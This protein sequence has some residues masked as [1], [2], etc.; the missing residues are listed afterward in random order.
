M[1]YCEPTP[2][3]MDDRLQDL[4]AGHPYAYFF[5]KNSEA[6]DTPTNFKGKKA[7]PCLVRV[8]KSDDSTVSFGSVEYPHALWSPYLTST[9]RPILSFSGLFH[10][11]AKVLSPAVAH[12]YHSFQNG[13]ACR[14]PAA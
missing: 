3:T 11:A 12:A 7:V 5:D 6:A 10:S 14:S 8:T 4:D 9:T 1:A 13:H 2:A